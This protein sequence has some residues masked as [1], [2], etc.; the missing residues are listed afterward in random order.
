MVRFSKLR[1]KKNVRIRDG[2]LG[3]VGAVVRLHTEAR[4]GM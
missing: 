1:R 3:T 4:C 2:A